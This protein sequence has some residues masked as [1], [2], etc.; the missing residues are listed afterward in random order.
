MSAK[1][2]FHHQSRPL[3]PVFAPFNATSRVMH[4]SG[5]SISTP[6]ETM[7]VINPKKSVSLI[8]WAQILKIDPHLPACTCKTEQ[9]H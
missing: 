4:I 6:W 3:G 7:K 9:T 5:R 1:A 2:S 8:V